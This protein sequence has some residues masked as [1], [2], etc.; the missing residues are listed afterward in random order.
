MPIVRLRKDGP[1]RIFTQGYLFERNAPRDDIPMD[2]CRELLQDKRFKIDLVAGEAIRQPSQEGKGDMKGRPGVLADR[3]DA[4]RD[5][6]ADLN[7][8]DDDNFTADGK[9]DARILTSMLGWQVTSEERDL[10]LKPK[11]P[12]GDAKPAR[13]KITLTRKGKAAEADKL[14]DTG[15]DLAGMAEDE[16][17]AVEA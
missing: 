16:E 15:E 8:D 14:L 6:I 17:E 10:A 11:L 1:L 4:I 5:A 7:V 13:G 9:P 3:L 12:A 2:V